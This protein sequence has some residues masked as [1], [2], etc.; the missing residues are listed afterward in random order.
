MSEKTVGILGGMGP[1]ATIDLFQRIVAET[2]AA[3]EEDHL[4]ILVDCNPK[5]PSRQDAILHD[6]PSPVPALVETARN[7]QRAG[8]DFLILGANT[9][10]Y[11]LPEVAAQV[12]IPFLSILEE[13]VKE[14]L[15]QA[16]QA[17]QVGVL[18]TSAA[19]EAGL[20]QSA[21]EGHGLHVLPLEPHWQQTVQT[22]IFHF[23]YH[24]LAPEN[25]GPMVSAAQHLVEL[26]AQ[27]LILGCTEIPL[28]LAGEEFP[29]PAIDPNLAIA[30]AVV[31]YA[32]GVSNL[33]NPPSVIQKPTL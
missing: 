33:D 14:L 2:H 15:R 3:K 1:E 29:V 9:A 20:Y 17:K 4:H 19:M 16:P 8:A 11:F 13:G 22:A 25:R 10:H 30:W 12:E 18:A 27:A 24:G 21:C 26:G 23:K 32:K 6:G 28:I 5:M 31:A 7:L